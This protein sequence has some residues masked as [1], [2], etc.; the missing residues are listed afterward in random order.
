MDKQLTYSR[1]HRQL[2]LPGF[3]KE[4][5]LTLLSAKVLVVGAGGL[6]CPVLMALGGAGVGH[7]GIADDGLV[8]LSNLHR[9]LIYATSDVGQSKVACAE[10]VLTA[11]NPEVS[12]DTYPVRLGVD[13]AWDIVERYDLIIDGTD[14]FQT[15][16]MLSDLCALL[17]KPLL[18][19]AVARYEGQV[20][21]FH[22]GISYRD[23]FP[24]PP[25]EGEV[26]NCS[27][28]GVLGVLPG[29]IGH[30]MAN[31]CIKFLTGI[32]DTLLGR[33]LTYTALDNGVFIVD[34]PHASQDKTSFPENRAAFEA[35]DYPAFCGVVGQEGDEIDTTGFLALASKGNVR[36]V[37]VRE[38]NEK[39]DLELAGIDC[40]RT[41]LSVFSPDIRAGSR[42]TVVFV[43]Q[44]GKR[45]LQAA[46]VYKA[47]FPACAAR[48][49][50]LKGGINALV[51]RG[52]L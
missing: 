47:A 27:E 18:F 39:P 8:E 30:F 22:H 2:I 31:E 46:N 36:V 32:G 34:I 4:A 48:T 14:N 33:L 15:R 37:D 28:A 29:I 23:V 16:Y 3:G 40:Q 19:G 21:L 45:S 9:Q 10:R 38:Y 13:N 24:V 42:E 17:G 1:Y 51:E 41:P 5:Q 52:V 44:S 35:T 43:C 20:A 50:S 11:L 26:P 49:Y 12:V 25:R 6:G 7:I